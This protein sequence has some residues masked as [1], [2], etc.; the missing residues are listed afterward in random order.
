MLITGRFYPL[1]G[2]TNYF[3]IKIF[4]YMYMQ[5]VL[6]SIINMEPNNQILFNLRNCTYFKSK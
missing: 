6:D 5:T 1:V 4:L 2:D 3:Y